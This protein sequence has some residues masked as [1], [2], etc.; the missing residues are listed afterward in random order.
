MSILNRLWR[1]KHMEQQLE[2]ELWFHLDQYTADL[3]AHGH[4]PDEARR[5][6][7]LALGGPEQ[8]KEKC[9]DARGTRW[10]EDLW[11]DFRY[12]L[13]TLRQRPAFSAVAL[14]TLALGTGATTVMFTVINGVLLKPVPYSDPDRLAALQ[15]QTDW[16]TQ[17]GNLWSFTYPNFVDCKR[18][19]RS[20]DMTAWR[21]NG[22]TISAP[23]QAE[24]IDAR[25]ISSNFL[26][27]LG[28]S[29][30][31]R[32]TFLAEEDRL[33]ADPVAIISYGLWQSRFGGSPG[34]LGVPLVFEGKSYTV[35]GILPAGFRLSGDEPDLY[36]LLGQDP[37]PRLQNRELH[38]IHVWARLRPGVKLSEAQAELAAIGHRLSEQ[39]PKSNKGRIFIADPLRPDVGNVRSTLW[40]LLG[41]VS[42]VL[43]IACVNVASLLL[44]R[45]RVAAT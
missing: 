35:A 2:K 39:Y 44:A 27:V 25:E 18:E 9:R 4:N 23:G 32:R 8:V 31:R 1:R 24:Y 43:L 17:V 21:F 41:A 15:E 13:R 3:I 12:A 34:A 28:V 10:L 16:S 26:S 30:F 6:A 40:L 5:Q 29:A 19:S 42:L 45:G 36:T 33:G 22:G 7:R 14:L 38:G 37:S 11:Q 20:L